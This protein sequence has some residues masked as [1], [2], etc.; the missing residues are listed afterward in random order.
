MLNSGFH[1]LG[2]FTLNLFSLVLK[3]VEITWDTKEI[4]LNT[5]AHASLLC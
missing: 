4:Q 2:I 1:D 3:V 5:A